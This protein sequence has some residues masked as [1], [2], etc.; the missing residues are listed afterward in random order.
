MSISMNGLLS[1]TQLRVDSPR[2]KATGDPQ[3]HRLGPADHPL[4]VV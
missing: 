1:V 4:L 3:D 2:L